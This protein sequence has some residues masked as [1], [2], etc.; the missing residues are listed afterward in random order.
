MYT[1]WLTINGAEIIN[2]HRAAAYARTAGLP[3]VAPCE[4]CDSIATGTN[5]VS[6]LKDTAKPPWWGSGSDDAKNFLG[7]VGVSFDNADDSTRKTPTTEG[8]S[9]GGYVGALRYTMRTLTVRA[10]AIAGDDCSLGYGLA[11]LRS[12][13]SNATCSAS[14]IGVYECCPHL[15][16]ADCATPECVAACVTARQR[17]Y[18]NARVTTGPTVLRRTEMGAM[19][20][21]AEIEF[22]I[23][24][25]D[26]YIY[27]TVPAPTYLIPDSA[28]WTDEPVPSEEPVLDPFATATVFAAPPSL[29]RTPRIT[30]RKNWE[31]QI[32]ALESPAFGATVVPVVSVESAEG[33]V[34]DVRVTLTRDG[35][36]VSQFYI[37]GLP[38]G[39]RV[40]VDYADRE[41]LTEAAGFSRVNQGYV[42][43]PDGWPIRWTTFPLG[44][45]E[46]VVDRTPGSEPLAVSA[47]LVGRGTA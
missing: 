29:R 3:W 36:A 13:D 25:G 35:L 45:Y 41:V 42:L 43:D 23:T 6:P 12:M 47:A 8:I 37:P 28:G 16:A 32:V 40:V 10:V 31:R 14:T 2:T 5:Y 21:M 44:E 11:W 7:V 4:D 34:E 38:D 33:S 46:V 22:I 30:L 39:G 17:S 1:G 24:A 27:N 20:A 18:R 19:G 9:D 26:P 15:S